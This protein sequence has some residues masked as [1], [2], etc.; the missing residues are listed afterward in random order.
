MND[1]F[2]RYLLEE[3]S[4]KLKAVSSHAWKY[5]SHHEGSPKSPFKRCLGILFKKYRIYN[6]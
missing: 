1:Q 6:K 2:Y 3:K 5:E 4:K